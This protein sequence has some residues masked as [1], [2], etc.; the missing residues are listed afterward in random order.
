MESGLPGAPEPSLTAAVRQ[1][2]FMAEEKPTEKFDKL[3]LL[4]TTAKHM[5]IFEVIKKKMLI[6]KDFKCE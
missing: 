5:I 3:S 2:L 4:H 6:T 1:F